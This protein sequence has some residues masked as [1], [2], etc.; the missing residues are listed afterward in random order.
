M[1]QAWWTSCQRG[2]AR[3]WWMAGTKA[4]GNMLRVSALRFGRRERNRVA[5]TERWRPGQR[6]VASLE[7]EKSYRP[8]RRASLCHELGLNCVS[9]SPYRVPVARLAAAQAAIEEKRAAAK[10]K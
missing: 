6:E 7:W 10:R 5:R 4:R 9:G 1:S 8:C 2:E 3:G